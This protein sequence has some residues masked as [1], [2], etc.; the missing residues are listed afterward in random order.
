[1]ACACQEPPTSILEAAEQGDAAAVRQMLAADPDLVR[2][3][4]EELRTPLHFAA[5]SGSVEMVEVLLEAGADVNAQT[6][7]G[8]TPLHRALWG[9]D[10]ELIEALLAADP[11]LTIENSYGRTPLLRV[12]RET[13]DVEMAARLLDAG[14]EIGAVDRFG[15]SSLDLAAWR[16][17]EPLVDLL[18][19]R[20]ATFPTTSASLQEITVNSAQHGLARPFRLAVEAGADLDVG[21]GGGGTL[22]HSAAAGGSAE[23]VE[24]LREEGMQIDA[25]DRYGWT[26]LHYAAMEGHEEVARTLIALGAPLEVRTLAGDSPYNLAAWAEH[27]S[28]LELLESEGASGEP[29]VFPQFEGPYFGQDPPGP[30]PI[31]FALDIVSSNRQEHGSVTFSADGQ[32]AFWSSS[33]V[34]DDSG[35]VRGRILTSRQT[36]K[37]WTVPTFASFSPDFIGDDVPQFS[38]DGN[39]VYFLSGRAESPLGEGA[40]ERIWY[41]DRTEDGWGEPVLIEGGPNELSKHWQFSVAASGNIYFNSGDAGGLGRGDIY[42]S[43]LR[44]GRWESPENL[45]LAINSEHEEFSPFMAPDKSYLIVSVMGRPENI[46][47]IDLYISFRNE[48]GEWMPLTH[49]GEAVNSMSHDLCPWVSSDGAYLFFNSHRGGQADIYWMDAT[50]IEA[51]RPTAGT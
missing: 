6:R 19:D 25:P 29:A 50:V 21:S 27:A 43:R 49:M 48:A 26:P 34:V 16:G 8:E 12:A 33:F 2:S 46:G 38:A 40:G 22:P 18:L 24:I 17:N 4:D 1:L 37:G 44:D 9:D 13:G 42:V 45:G 11:D 3:A 28:M 47:S 31:P 32:E 39:R 51:L 10:H 36:E 5:E 15:A 35:Y 14:A 30:E 7:G 20:G 23:V 41:V